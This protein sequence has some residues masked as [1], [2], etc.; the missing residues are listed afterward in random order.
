MLIIES[1]DVLKAQQQLNSYC[2][3]VYELVGSPL[4]P[5]CGRNTHETDWEQE[6]GYRRAH[7]EKMG[8]F[9]QAT[10]VWWSI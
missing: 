4:C 2:I 5:H 3:H 9:H 6:L 10:P 8:L 1:L 7:V